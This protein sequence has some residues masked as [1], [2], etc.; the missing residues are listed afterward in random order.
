M[1]LAL[2]WAVSSHSVGGRRA[3]CGERDLRGDLLRRAAGHVDQAHARELAHPRELAARVVA[4]SSLPRLRRRRRAAPRSPTPG[5]RPQRPRRRARAAPP[6]G[7]PRRA[8]PAHARRSVRRAPRAPSSAPQA[9]SGGAPPRS[10]AARGPRAARARRPR[11]TPGHGRSAGG[12]PG[13]CPRPPTGRAGRGGR[14]G[15][16]ARRVRARRSA[17]RARPRGVAVASAAR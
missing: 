5:A 2:D 9:A 12:P 13:R 7:P 17:A 11:A 8:S 6:R 15:P 16:P 14:A 1:V 3:A 10:T 4:G